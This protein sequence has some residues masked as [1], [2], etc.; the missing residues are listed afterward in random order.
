MDNGIII[1]SPTLLIIDSAGQADFPVWVGSAAQAK[2]FEPAT[3]TSG[4]CSPEGILKILVVCI[5]CF[6]GSRRA[7]GG[8]ASI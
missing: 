2:H 8:G 5:Y 4:E 3:H 1:N 6:W 7:L